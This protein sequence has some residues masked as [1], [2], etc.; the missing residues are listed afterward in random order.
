MSFISEQRGA[1]KG[2]VWTPQPAW[3]T[4]VH[5]DKQRGAGV[6]EGTR[7]PVGNACWTCGYNAGLDSPSSLCSAWVAPSWKASCSST[8]SMRSY[9]RKVARKRSTI[10]RRCF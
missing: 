5:R 2:G 1:S 7:Q 3:T 9:V 6:Q 10:N 4:G 8:S